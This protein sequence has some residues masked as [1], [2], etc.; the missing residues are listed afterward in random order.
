MEAPEGHNWPVITWVSTF[1]SH[2]KYFCL[3]W[4][5]CSAISSIFLLQQF[6]KIFTIHV[7][8]PPKELHFC[9]SVKH[10]MFFCIIRTSPVSA[11]SAA[12]CH[13]PSFGGMEWR[14][15]CLKIENPGILQGQ[16][17]RNAVPICSGHP[18]TFRTLKIWRRNWIHWIPDS[19]TTYTQPKALIHWM[20]FGIPANWFPAT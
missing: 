17:D 18:A 6:W 7:A 5:L 10:G 19:E 3:Q 12:H 11:L 2:F 1:P 4:M 20:D 13:I 16:A 8:F 15:W 14:L 9:G